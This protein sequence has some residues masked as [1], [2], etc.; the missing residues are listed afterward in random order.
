MSLLMNARQATKRQKLKRFE[1]KAFRTL[2]RIDE[3]Q[4][5]EMPSSVN[6]IDIHLLFDFQ[7]LS[8]LRWVM[9]LGSSPGWP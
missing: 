1:L 3:T 4:Y 9:A 8:R 7:Y 2:L 5:C 6:L